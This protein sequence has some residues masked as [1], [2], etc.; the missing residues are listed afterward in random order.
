MSTTLSQFVVDYY[1][2]KFM[3]KVQN[4]DECTP[5][6]D[7]HAFTFAIHTLEKNGMGNYLCT[8]Y[9]IPF[10]YNW[11]GRD[12]DIS[13]MIDDEHAIGPAELY[14]IWVE[15]IYH[16][17]IKDPAIIDTINNLMAIIP[18]ALNVRKVVMEGEF[19]KD[20]TRLLKTPEYLVESLG[21]NLVGH[22]TNGDP[23]N[24]NDIKKPIE[25]FR[26]ALGDKPEM[27]M[28]IVGD[29][30]PGKIEFCLDLFGNH[31]CATRTVDILSKHT[32]FCGV[33][34]NIYE[35]GMKIGELVMRKLN[36]NKDFMAKYQD[37]INGCGCDGIDSMLDCLGDLV[38]EYYPDIIKSNIANVDDLGILV[39]EALVEC[40]KDKLMEM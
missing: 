26:Q 10:E 6:Y 3:A 8:L 31:E 36:T 11:I 15:A 14:D 35:V 1:N 40:A 17:A 25:Y 12:A 4:L 5:K 18:N 28:R 2:P 22:L 7:P 27:D 23:D 39:N 24:P 34:L 37:L 16:V 33:R 9:I 20:L 32:T 19:C 30:F 29:E 13:I 38:G 21:V